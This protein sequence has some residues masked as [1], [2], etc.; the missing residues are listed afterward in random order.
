MARVDQKFFSQ[1]TLDI[2]QNLLGKIIVSKID[3]QTRKGRI[4]ETEAYIGSDDLACHARFGRTKRTETMYAPAGRA[5]I[6]LCYGIHELLNIVTDKEGSPAAVLIRRIEPLTEKDPKLKSY[7]PGN[8]TRYLNISRRE[9]NL[10]LISSK[11]LFLE[12]DDFATDS[13]SIKTGKRVGVSY[14]GEWADKLWRFY[15]DK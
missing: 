8:L 12:D 5:Y 6:Y 4:V 3:G 2:A 7:G 10:D 15:L 14:A 9:N 13:L 1:D 11:I